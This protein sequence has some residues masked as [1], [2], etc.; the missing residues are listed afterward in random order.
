MITKSKTKLSLGLLVL[1]SPF[2]GFPLLALAA[3]RPD[4]A[5]VAII[6]SAYL[7]SLAGLGGCLGWLAF[8]LITSE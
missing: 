2:W 7:L 4:E 3:G 6:T 5:V 8:N 1:L